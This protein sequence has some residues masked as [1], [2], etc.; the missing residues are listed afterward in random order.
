MFK[1]WSH[2]PAWRFEVFRH[3]PLYLLLLPQMIEQ[4]GFKGVD[5]ENLSLGVVAIHS[6]FKMG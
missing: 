4:A 6:A 5:Y 2:L 1:R 3:P